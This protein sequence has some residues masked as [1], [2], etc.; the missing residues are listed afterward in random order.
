MFVGAAIAGLAAL[1]I[2]QLG[3]DCSGSGCPGASTTTVSQDASSTTSVPAS[4]DDS[5]QLVAHLLDEVDAQLPGS[6]AAEERDVT[7]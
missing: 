4:V 3:G 6:S 5:I 7:G 1:G 2:L